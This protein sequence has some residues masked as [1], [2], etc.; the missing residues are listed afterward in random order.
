MGCIAM[1]AREAEARGAGEICLNS[2]DADGMKQGY[3]LELTQLIS[4]GVNIPVI[5]SGGAES[6]HLVDVLSETKA[7]AALVASMVHYGT[8]S[9]SGIKEDLNKASI[10][11]RMDW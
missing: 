6:S 7:E 5:A 10:P 1:N 9:C 3:D 8:H 4:T 11:V 2:I